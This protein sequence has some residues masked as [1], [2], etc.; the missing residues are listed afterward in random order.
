M[1]P[2]AGPAGE[3][4]RI[5]SAVGSLFDRTS[6]RGKAQLSLLMNIAARA[7]SVIGIL[8]FV[9][10]VY[11]ELGD[12]DYGRLMAA[13]SLGGLAS[14]LLGGGYY[15]GR[16]RV[17]EAMTDNRHDAESEA[18]LTLMR[19]SWLA[20]V[21]GMAAAV[22]YALWQ[23]WT[24]VFIVIAVLQILAGLTGALDEVRTAYNEL[25][26]TATLRAILQTLAYVVGLTMAWVARSPML[27]ALVMI[28]PSIAASLFSTG[29]LLIRRPYLLKG[30]GLSAWHALREALPIGI[31]DGLVMLAV[32]LSVVVVQQALPAQSSAW[33]ATIVRITILLLTLAMLCVL[34]LTSYFRG[35]WN[36]R[37]AA[38]RSRISFYWMALSFGFGVGTTL[39][40]WLANIVYLGI[41]MGIEAPF[42]SLETF[43]IY[44]G[45]GAVSAFKFYTAFGYIIMDTRSLNISFGLVLLASFLAAALGQL[46]AGTAEAV[47]WCA[48]VFAVGTSLAI[49]NLYRTDQGIRESAWL[50]RS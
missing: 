11:R 20:A 13:I 17:G 5:V 50:E 23:S 7:P 10:L 42:P 29:H 26:F 22:A 8:F 44:A 12:A 21:I 25:Y 47:Q 32:N 43:A 35:I 49:V 33:Y 18:F 6:H 46:V 1:T 2:S 48:L 24:A 34:P 38:L 37:P 14:V 41:I 3:S 36:Q 9:P 15:L 45:L 27:A 30:T 19:A 16:R 31:I 28:G 4:L 40:L 39:A